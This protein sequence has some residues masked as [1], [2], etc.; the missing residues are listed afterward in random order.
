MHGGDAHGGK[1]AGFRSWQL[2]KIKK[3]HGRKPM[4][5]FPFLS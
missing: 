2:I 1:F 3:P 4:L 5:A